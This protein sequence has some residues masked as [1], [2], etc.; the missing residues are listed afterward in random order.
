MGAGDKD[1]RLICFSAAAAA[2]GGAVIYAGVELP[3]GVYSSSVIVV[4]SRLMMGTIPRNELSTIMLIS[5]LPF[6]VRR[7]LGKRVKEVICH[8]IHYCFGVVLQQPGEEAE[9]L[10]PELGFYHHQDDPVDSKPRG[11]GPIAALPCGVE[12]CIH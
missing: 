8:R 4:K 3:P 11:L 5:E 9:T 6:V 2:S 7:T 12:L 10:C 1:I